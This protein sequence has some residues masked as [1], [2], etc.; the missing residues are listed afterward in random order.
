M[1]SQ[2]KSEYQI[3]TKKIKY[4]A[5]IIKII[6]SEKNNYEHAFFTVTSI[7]KKI[8]NAY[9]EFNI[10]FPKYVPKPLRKIKYSKQD[11]LV[12]LSSELIDSVFNEEILIKE[13]EKV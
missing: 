6:S 11:E 1:L 3:F 5:D 8:I 12:I 13:F 7:F 9:D 10:E 4:L 2:N